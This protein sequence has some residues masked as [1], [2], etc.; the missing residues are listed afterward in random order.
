MKTIRHLD[1]FSGI[2]GFALGFKRASE[3]FNT[4]C[5][6]E[7]NPYARAVLARHFPST[8]LCDDV[9]TLNGAEYRA[10]LIT[11]GFP[12]QDL[13]IAGKQ[14]GLQGSRSGLFY[15]TLRIADE[16]QATSI[17]YE[18]S[19]ELIWRDD[20][21]EVFI[22]ELQERGWGVV[23]RIC[24]ARECGLPHERK[25]VYAL[26]FKQEAITDPHSLRCLCAQKLFTYHTDEIPQEPSKKI[27][28]LLRGYLER[29][30]RGDYRLDCR[31]IRGDDGL[32]TK[33]EQIHA[34]GNAIIPAIATK[35]GKIIEAIYKQGLLAYP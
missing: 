13:S 29:E 14:K 31:D 30:E 28:S 1:L 6:V 8:P 4:I 32:P 35:W 27:I 11:A 10:D 7:I 22:K 15:H 18:N 9:V 19:P 12:C 24:S 5:F 3:A 23:W 26:C 16:S 21:R 33:L 17:L 25:R 34:L 2:G 20:F